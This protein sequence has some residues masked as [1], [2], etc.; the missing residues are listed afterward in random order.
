ME[1]S[2]CKTDLYCPGELREEQGGRKKEKTPCKE[3]HTFYNMEGRKEVPPWDHSLP[4]KLE[5]SKPS[6]G[7]L[8]L[9]SLISYIKLKVKVGENR[10]GTC[11][12]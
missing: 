6:P 5:Q 3:N 9:L 1:G 7:W 8:G 2:D 11:A 4:G 12:F 10:E